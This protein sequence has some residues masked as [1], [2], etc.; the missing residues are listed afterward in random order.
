MTKKLVGDGYEI[1]A[2][3]VSNAQNGSVDPKVGNYAGFSVDLLLENKD[4]N[5][6]EYND[7]IIA[8][9][10]RFRTF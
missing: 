8:S 2:G 6:Y 10:L 3:G 9:K 7:T 5:I 1:I 4:G